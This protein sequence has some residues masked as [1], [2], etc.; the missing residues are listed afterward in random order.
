MKKTLILLAILI[1]LIGTYFLLTQSDSETISPQFSDR[2]FAVDDFD[3]VDKIFIRERAKEGHFI[4]RKGDRWYKDDT[5]LIDKS[6]MSNL[7]GVLSKMAI[8]YIPQQAEADVIRTN[9]NQVGIEVKLFDED[10]EMIRDYWV[11]R[12]NSREDGTALMVNGG[13]QP[14]MMELPFTGGSLR[15]FFLL[16]DAGIREKTVMKLDPSTIEKVSVNYPKHTSSAFVLDRNGSSFSV[17]NF[18]Q[19]GTAEKRELNQKAV[20]NFLI[21]FE[22]LVCESFE[23]QNTKRQSIEST[24]PFMICDVQLS[25]GSTRSLK[26]WSLRNFLDQEPDP[27]SRRTLELVE[28]FFMT[29]DEEDFY[30]V[31]Y[32]LYKNLMVTYN[33]FYNR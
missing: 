30:V 13:K 5:L 8:K 10:N 25:D 15:S 26:F 28:R 12:N 23:N 24:V 29:A 21:E 31:Q 14:Y 27:Q 32:R 20:D 2:A 4:Q 7:G 16:R 3:E 1:A 6:I 18:Y 19:T 33:F 9:L 17:E 22:N 11:G